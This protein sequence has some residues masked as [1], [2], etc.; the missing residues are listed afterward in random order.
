MCI[1]QSCS[2]KVRGLGNFN[3]KIRNSTYHQV[4]HRCSSVLSCKN[5]HSINLL[6]S[7]PRLEHN[8]LSLQNHLVHLSPNKC[9]LPTYYQLPICNFPQQQN[10]LIQSISSAKTT[11]YLFEINMEWTR[12]FSINHILN[13][14][15]H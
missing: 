13:F 8:P 12:F 15:T 4:S 7:K 5:R 2:Q 14:V 11:V 10:H 6:K 9:S 1:T 3:K